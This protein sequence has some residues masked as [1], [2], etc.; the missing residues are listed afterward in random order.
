MTRILASY[1]LCHVTYELKISS[2]N[3]GLAES[4][5]KPNSESSC[6]LPVAEIISDKNARAWF[7]IVS[8][9]KK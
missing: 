6:T 4:I 1:Q 8:Y 3:L 7:S 9:L 2:I 5:R